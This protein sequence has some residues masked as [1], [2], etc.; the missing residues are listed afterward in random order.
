MK[1]LAEISFEYIWLLLFDGEDIIDLDYSVKMQESLPD[2]FAAMSVEEKVA[3]S[4][5]AAKTKS[6]LLADPDEHGYSPRK[7]VTDEQITFLDALS[8]GE[9]FEQWV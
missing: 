5:V 3:L 9:I 4:Q 7:L 1:I 6:K 2:Y 8:S